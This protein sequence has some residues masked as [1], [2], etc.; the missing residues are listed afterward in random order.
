M[1]TCTRTTLSG[2]GDEEQVKGGPKKSAL[3][4]LRAIFIS[5][6]WLAEPNTFGQSIAAKRQGPLMATA[7]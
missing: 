3:Y 1:Q 6:R 5:R 4:R 2:R 7:L